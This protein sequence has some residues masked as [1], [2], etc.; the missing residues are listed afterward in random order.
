MS[1]Y[2]PLTI[3]DEELAKLDEQYDDVFVF[4]GR[5]LS[6]WIAVLRRPTYDDTQAYKA[7]AQEPMKRSIANTKLITALC[8][9]P[10]GNSPEWKAQLER[11]PFFVDGICETDDFKDF[12]G[13]SVANSAK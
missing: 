8:V 12:V 7:L 6:P 3:S 9:F 4:K 13:M 5:P 1:K 11:W 10:K 2:Q